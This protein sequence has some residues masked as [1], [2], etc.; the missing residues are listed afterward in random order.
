MLFWY[1]FINFVN[2][3]TPKYNVQKL[4]KHSIIKKNNINM[5]QNH[6]NHKIIFRYYLLNIKN[7]KTHNLSVKFKD[8][9]ILSTIN[10]NI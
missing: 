6:N 2:L 5:I 8:I 1:P 10:N 4:Y 7:C 3:P 9:L